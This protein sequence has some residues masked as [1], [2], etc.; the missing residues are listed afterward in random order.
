MGKV[1]KI[2][3]NN[4]DEKAI[5]EIVSYLEKG[6]IIIFPTDSYYAIGC[7]INSPKSIQE[8]KLFKGKANKNMSLICSDIK[9]ASEYV[10]IDDSAFKLL[11]ANTPNP[12]TFVLKA[13]S[14]IP[15]SFF[16]KKR[17]LGIRIPNNKITLA[18]VKELSVPL[19][20]TSIPLSR[21]SVEESVDPSII[22][23]EYCNRA[24]VLVDAGIAVNEP[25]TVVD[26]SGDEAQILRQSLFEL[27]TL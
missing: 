24:D 5:R 12:V 11:K 3:E 4:P 6:G 13:S 15:N 22:W 8:I 10:L 2:Y 27:E 7:S 20:S 1:I 25:T 21:A 23:D 19:V 26:I 14:K 9:M 16:E 17:T 18:L